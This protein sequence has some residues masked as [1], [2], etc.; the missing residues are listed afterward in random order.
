MS[1]I[2]VG[3]S[4]YTLSDTFLSKIKEKAND[5][6]VNKDELKDLESGATESEKKFLTNEVKKYSSMDLGEGIKFAT[7]KDSNVTGAFLKEVNSKAK[8]GT[9]DKA[10][11]DHLK[12]KTTNSDETKFIAD[13]EKLDSYTNLTV[14][15]DNNQVT[16]IKKVNMNY[17]ENSEIPGKTNEEIV[18][19]IGQGDR[20]D[21]TKTDP[22]RCGAACVVN[23]AILS[24]GKEGFAK[25]AK[26]LGLTDTSLT[27][28]NVH[29]A[30]DALFKKVKGNQSTGLAISVTQSSNGTKVSGTLPDAIRAGGK[31]PVYMDNK[32]KKADIEKF[33]KDNPKAQ[34][35]VN[36][37][38]GDNG[39]EFGKGTAG[40]KSQDHW[41][42]MTYDSKSGKYSIADSYSTSG[43]GK[44]RRE[45]SHAEVQAI[46]A[47]S[48]ISVGMK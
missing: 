26:D 7:F 29:K 27:Y 47:S 19:N 1:E 36:C 17:D 34:M 30:Q 8:D 40:A 44:N 25:L 38:R 46:F 45:L 14:L 5:G 28:A 22:A 10:D 31:E 24:G 39:I 20:L 42:T 15:D 41:V 18:S 2:S 21:E 16:Q 12:T 11:F 6:V 48:R 43:T 35:I 13:L 32:N 37:S 3:A 23:S 9:L 4:K 33:F